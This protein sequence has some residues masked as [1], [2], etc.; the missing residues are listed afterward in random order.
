M[1]THFWYLSFKN[2]SMIQWRFDSTNI[3]HLHFC[4][5]YSKHLRD[6][7]SQNGTV[8]IHCLYFPTLVKMWIKSQNTFPTHFYFHALILIVS[9]SLKSQHKLFLLT[10]LEIIVNVTNL[11]LSSTWPSKGQ[12][13]LSFNPNL[14]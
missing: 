6:F 12:M 1:W 5:Q 7:N 10:F 11:N 9:P 4:F 13:A 14:L 3:C 8:R 2:N